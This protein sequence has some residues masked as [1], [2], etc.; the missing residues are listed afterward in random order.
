MSEPVPYKLKYEVYS[1]DG[2]FVARCLDID[3]S[4]DGETDAE[5][6]ENLRLAI[7]LYLERHAELAFKD[8]EDEDGHEDADSSDDEFDDPDVDY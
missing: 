5:A 1:E 4:S 8:G 7:E 6:V 2:I 3:V